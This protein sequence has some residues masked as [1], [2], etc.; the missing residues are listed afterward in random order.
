VGG[1]ASPRSLV[2][3]LDKEYGVYLL[4]IWGMTETSPLATLGAPT[5]PCKP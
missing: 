5:K 1:S 2:E 3:T 4:P